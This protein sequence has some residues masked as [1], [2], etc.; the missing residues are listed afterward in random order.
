MPLQ[1]CY[2]RPFWSLI[3]ARSWCTAAW[4]FF[5]LQISDLIG[6]VFSCV[7]RLK[8]VLF[9]CSEK[10]VCRQYKP[11]PLCISCIYRS[12][13]SMALI[14]QESS[15]LLYGLR[16]FL[17][18]SKCIHLAMWL[19]ICGSEGI[20]QFLFLNF[21]SDSKFVHVCSEKIFPR[22][23]LLR[24]HALS[25]DICVNFYWPL[26]IT[27]KRKIN[28]LQSERRGKIRWPCVKRNTS[29]EKKYRYRQYFSNK[30]NIS[31][32]L[33][34]FV[35]VFVSCQI[36][37]VFRECFLLFLRASLVHCLLLQRTK[38]VT[39]HR[40]FPIF[41]LNQTHLCYCDN[42]LHPASVWSHSGSD[43]LVVILK[44]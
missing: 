27:C 41:I 19:K 33:F 36:V 3:F 30:E 40:E 10:G 2:G 42:R 44:L 5:F 13:A 9:A 6:D 16:C 15:T 14:F 37:I 17:L 25:Y 8:R 43:E 4:S 28:K 20:N 11:T 23:L 12:L 31:F 38:Y 7:G 1:A 22:S 39:I 34:L 18:V 24:D 32:V 29:I 26:I 35:Y 21:H